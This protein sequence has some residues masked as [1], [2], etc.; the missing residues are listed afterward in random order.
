MNRRTRA[1]EFEHRRSA[2]LVD[3]LDDEASNQP[4]S[5]DSLGQSHARKEI[6]PVPRARLI[7]QRSEV[8]VK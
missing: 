3:L 2:V 7:R 1:V 8:Q 4:T 6:R 5:V